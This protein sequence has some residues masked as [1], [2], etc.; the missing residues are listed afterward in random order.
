[1]RRTLRRMTVAALC[2]L[3]LL[4]SAGVCA[5]QAAPDAARRCTLTLEYSYEGTPFADVAV[6]VYR[7]AEVNPDGTYDLIPPYDG[8]PVSIH[9]ITAQQEWRDV[10]ATLT[11]YVTADGATPTAEGITDDAG[12]VTL[13]DLPVGLYLVRDTRAEN[14]TGDYVFR[15]FMIYLPTPTEDGTYTYDL[16]AKPKCEQYTPAETYRV[17]KLWKDSGS[18]IRPDEVAVDIYKNGAHHETVTL[19]ADNG[20]SYEWTDRDAAQW[21]VTERDVPEGYQVAVTHREWVFTITNT[22]PAPPPDSP[23]TGDSASVL[24]WVTVACLSGFALIWIG[25]WGQRNEKTK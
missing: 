23:Q 8:Y 7:V 13:T 11:A 17:V 9:G 3:T 19:N 22:N 20:W 4:C 2:L 25:L 16:R 6:A 15:E 5:V 10:A 12:E 24:L 18:V 21:Q 1:M 14:E